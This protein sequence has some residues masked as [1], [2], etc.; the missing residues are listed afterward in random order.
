MTQTRLG[1]FIEAW[2]NV[3]IGFGINFAGNLLILPLFG[4]DVR[5]GQ[6]LGIGFLFTLVSVARSY[7]IRRWFNGWLHRQLEKKHG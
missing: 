3:A 2:V 7:A 1:S 6:A 5:A 4:F